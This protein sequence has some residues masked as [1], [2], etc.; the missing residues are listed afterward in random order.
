MLQITADKAAL[1]H[2][3]LQGRRTGLIDRG[4]AV[5]FSQSKNAQ[6]AANGW[7]TLAL[8][9]ML[10]ELPDMRPGFLARLNSFLSSSYL[11]VG[12]ERPDSPE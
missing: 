9:E 4:E 5:F 8:A 10:T 12:P 2:A 7:L 1:G 11:T 6:D 3:H